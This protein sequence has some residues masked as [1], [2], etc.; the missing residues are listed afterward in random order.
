LSAPSPP[1]PVAILLDLDDTII[2]AGVREGV[3]LEIAHSLADELAPLAPATVAAELEA[4]LTVY[5]S[6]PDRHRD[7]RFALA[8]VRRRVMAQAFAANG[9]AHMT[10]ALAHRFADAFTATREAMTAAF[11]GAI[12]AVA[13][14]KARGVRLGLITNGDGATQRAKIARFGLEGFFH[15]IQIEGEAGFGK[16]QPQAYAHALAALGVAAGDCWIVGDDLEWEVAA[17]QRLGIHAIW[18]DGWGRGLPADSAVVPDRIIRA[19]GEL[20]T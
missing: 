9:A 7:G 4:A 20:L 1:L 16:P 5:W 11:P 2:H 6:D 17:P 18:H 3:L 10:E 12:E 19:L 13:E 14:L 8:Q 15:H